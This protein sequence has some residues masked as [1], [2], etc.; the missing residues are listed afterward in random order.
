MDSLKYL[1]PLLLILPIVFNKLFRLYPG[2]NSSTLQFFSPLVFLGLSTFSY[3]Q[4]NPLQL[5][6]W[7]FSNYFSL[8]L[9]LDVL[10]GLIATTVSMIGIVVTRFSVR[11]LEDDPNGAVFSTNLSYTLSFVLSMLLAPNLIFLFL[12]WVGTSYF[13]HQLLTHFSERAGAMKAAQQKFWVSRL[14][15]AFIVSAGALL[16]IAFDSLEFEEIFKM[17]KDSLFLQENH[18]LINAISVLLVL[19][20]MTKSAQFP[21][22][23]WLPNTME[24]PTPVSAIMHAGIINAG[25]YLVIRMSPV[26]SNA[27]LAL[28]ILAIVGGFTAFWATIVM[29]TQPNIKRNLAYSTISQMGFMML[30]CGLGAFS[31]AVVH[32]IGHAFYKAYAFLSSGSAT[33][34]GR[35]NRYFPKPKVSQS[36]WAPFLQGC[37]SVTL[38][39]GSFVYSGHGILENPGGIIL[40]LIL[41]LAASQ[42]ILNSKDVI[43]ALLSARSRRTPG[44][45]NSRGTPRSCWKGSR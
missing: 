35:L 39:L 30:Q 24:T 18:L 33:D 40:L 3:I 43:R 28:S 36:L 15:D 5:T 34:F 4:K 11:Y 42:I 27:P 25:G 17:T 29:F 6:I 9:K 31:I 38:V 21:F 23:F 7:D 37:L 12:S 10:S 2:F 16:L 14:G 45:R 32:I 41:A 22:H 13:L 19:G 1:L 20:A 44:N 8:G 26:L